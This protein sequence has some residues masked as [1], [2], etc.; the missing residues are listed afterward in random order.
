MKSLIDGFEYD[1]F[2]SYR[3]KDNTYDAWVNTFVDHLRKELAATFKENVSIY[4]DQNTEDG[5]HV[6]HQVDE[7]ISHKVR[8]L[9]FIPILSKTYCDPK[10]FAWS[11]EFVAFCQLANTDGFGMRVEVGHSNVASRILPVCIHELD[12]IDVKLYEQTSGLLLRSID[13][14]FKSPGLNRPLRSTEDA[15]LENQKKVHYRDQINRVAMAIQEIIAGMQ[16][17]PAVKRPREKIKHRVK[18][19]PYSLAG[20]LILIGVVASLGIF[21]A[22]IFESEK[23][24]I[25]TN[26][27]AVLPFANL[28]H[29]A[30]QEFFSDGITEQIITEL[31]QINNLKVIARTSV[32]KYKSTAKSISEIGTDL[33]V[34]HVLE[35]SVR[36]Y[37]NKIRI[38]AQ[39]IEVKNQSHL[40]A[41]DY[42][43]N[44]GDIFRVQDEVSV[45]I[46]TTLKTRLTTDE[47]SS[48]KSQELQNPKAYEHYLKG[49]YIHEKYFLAMRDDKYF[50]QAE[51]EFKKALAL[52][53]QY[54]MALAGL[55]DVYDTYSFQLPA[56]GRRYVEKRDSLVEIAFR[57]D[58]HSYYT[59]L[60]KAFTFYNYDDPA[61]DLSDS[62][63]HYLKRAYRAAPSNI[64]VSEQI[65]IFFQRQGLWLNCLPFLKKSVELNPLEP[66]GPTWLGWAYVQLGDTEAAEVIFRNVIE[67]YPEI[68]GG[69]SGMAFS[70]LIQ[71]KVKEA[72]PYL[73]KAKEIK[74]DDYIVMSLDALLMASKGDKT[75][76]KKYNDQFVLVRLGLY[77]EAVE[78]ISKA[79]DQ[80]ILVKKNKFYDPLR[81]R[82]DYKK[83]MEQFKIQYEVNLRRFQ[84]EDL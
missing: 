57:I 12:A 77:K 49:A 75:A 11:H 45:R 9:I 60:I 78:Q 23:V 50:H 43:E 15:P 31:A 53:P 83:M 69:H 4:F 81:D 20:I 19:T 17:T 32:M 2:I 24:A 76:S 39:L 54:V 65:A 61:E 29:D 18:I 16:R 59:L 33:N 14:I 74:G 5:L 82:D 30:E 48:L 34:T 41:A 42:D 1:V 27:I 44:F 70:K 58:P 47:L 6:H 28:S 25:N 62:A 68:S 46:A 72:L 10:S 22:K 38:T 55:A 73:Q 56:D 13:F 66:I 63:F 21:K 26:S 36:R 84:F 7:S 51:S 71:N 80:Y 64:K 37:G 79:P 35:G 67:L 8:C 40:W 3:H 52:E